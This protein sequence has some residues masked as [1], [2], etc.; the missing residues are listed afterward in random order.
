MFVRAGIVLLRDSNFFGHNLTASIWHDG[1]ANKDHK[2][3]IKNSFFD[4]ANNFPLER[5]H[6]EA[7]FYFIGC[8]FSANMADRNIYQAKANPERELIWG[9][10][11]IYFHNCRGIKINYSWHADNLNLSEENPSPE[12]ITPI[13]VFNNQWDPVSILDSLEKKLKN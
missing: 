13:W 1:E 8:T 10:D 11:R 4:G 2:F 12:D 7:Q 5:F 3:V 6:R 9:D